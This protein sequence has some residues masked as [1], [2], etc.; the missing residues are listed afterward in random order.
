MQTH[1]KYSLLED[2]FFALVYFCSSKLSIKVQLYSQVVSNYVCHLSELS[3]RDQMITDLLLLIFNIASS[4]TGLV[5]V[6]NSIN[7]FSEPGRRM[8]LLIFK[9]L[10]NSDISCTSVHGVQDVL[11]MPPL[12][13]CRKIQK[14]RI[15]FATNTCCLLWASSMD[16]EMV[17]E[18]VK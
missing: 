13:D 3:E 14:S 16:F 5:F 8:Q 18:L 9:Q 11:K 15:L 4:T 17:I 12:F 2:R 7:V 6:V 1:L 10:R